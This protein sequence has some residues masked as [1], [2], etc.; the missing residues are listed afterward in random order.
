M[1]VEAHRSGQV[2]LANAD[3]KNRTDLADFQRSAVT[4]KNTVWHF[5]R[6][7]A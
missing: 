1:L 5:V 2:M 6:L 7:E 4:Y 3:L